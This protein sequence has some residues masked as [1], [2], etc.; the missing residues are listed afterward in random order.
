MQLYARFGVRECWIGDAGD[1]SL[2]IL[3]LEGGRYK[4]HCSAKEK[5]KLSSLVVAGL[6]FDLAEMQG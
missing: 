2:E 3:T 1:H 6:S 5:G 4:L